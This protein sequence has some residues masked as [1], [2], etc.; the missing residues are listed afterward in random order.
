MTTLNFNTSNQTFRQLFGNGLTYQIPR[1]QRDYSWD[2]DEWDDLWQDIQQTLEPEGEPAHY[3]G[4]LV[5]Q[6]QDSKNFAVIDGQQRLTTLTLLI[7]ATLKNLQ[8]LIEAQN[9]PEQNKLRL[10]QLRNSFIGFLD[11]VTL[12]SRNKLTLNRNND[13]YFRDYLIP[14]PKQL[15]RY[16]FRSSEHLLRKAFEWLYSKVKEEKYNGVQLAQFVSD[17]ADKLFFT[18]IT[19]TNELNAFKVFETLNARGVRLSPTDLL[20]NYLF[21]VV[22]KE[23][24]HPQEI[25]TLERRWENIVGRLGDDSFPHFLRVHWNSRQK[26]VRETELFKTIRANTPTKAQVFELIR[27]MDEDIEV[28]GG[29]RRPEETIWTPEQRQS[30]QELILF[31]VRQPWPLL[32]AARRTYDEYGFT[33]ILKA[34]AIITFRYNIIGERATNEQERVYNAVA[35]KISSKEYQRYGEVIQGLAPLYPNDELF[36]TSFIAKA[37]KTT[38]SRNA[39]IA[40]YILFKLEK[41]LSNTEYDVDSTRYTLEHILPQNPNE[42]WDS[43]DRK[44]VQEVVFRLGNFTLL[45]ADKNRGLGNLSFAEKKG[46]Y[47]SSEFLHTQ[48]VGQEEIWNITRLEAHQSWMAR[49]AISI[50]RIPQLH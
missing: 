11:P 19:V 7:L 25:E 8:D 23:V 42:Q 21:S 14:L 44:D 49:Q 37:L 18:V 1:F 4:Y 15:P 32:L 9:E 5:L 35:Q 30:I 50:W 6:T 24:N 41:Q 22:D 3:M 34:C 2:N 48:R 29:L 17:I 39:K 31:N 26:F 10:E 45:E 13:G 20:K 28:Y 40:R 43:F 38:A 12:V 33:Q 46:V 16:G 47:A 27:Q 36:R